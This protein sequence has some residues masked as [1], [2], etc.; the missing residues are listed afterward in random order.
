MSKFI[1][2]FTAALVKQA[3]LVDIGSRYSINL[4]R[5]GQSGRE[6]AC[7]DPRMVAVI[8]DVRNKLLELA[9]TSQAEGWECVLVRQP[10]QLQ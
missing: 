7:R 4:N 10:A 5:C 8:K 3:M 2:C 1:S 6:S 9:G